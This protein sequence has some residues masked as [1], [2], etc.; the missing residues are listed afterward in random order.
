MKPKLLA[1][2]LSLVCTITMAQIPASSWVVLGGICYDNDKSTDYDQV[3]STNEFVELTSSQST[4]EF[5]GGAGYAFAENQ[6]AGLK[7]GYE[8]NKDMNEFLPNPALSADIGT[9]TYTDTR[10]SINPFYRYYYF[11]APKFAIIGQLRVPIVFKNSKYEIE[12]GSNTT[13]QEDPGSFG[14]GAWLN[15][16]LAWFPKDNWSI[17]AG[18]GRL[19][20]YSEG[21]DDD[22]N[23]RIKDSKFSAKLWFFQPNLTVSYYFGRGDSSE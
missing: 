13:T 4:F 7:L 5:K 12:A 16:K 11:C 15:P 23:N 19:G 18:V 20:F 8:I 22:D 14:I 10:F 9:Q 3:I 2:A 6:V 17:E 1:L 21:Y